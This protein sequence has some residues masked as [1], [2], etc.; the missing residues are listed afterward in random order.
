MPNMHWAVK[1]GNFY[2]IASPFEEP[3]NEEDF[4]LDAVENPIEPCRIFEGSFDE[5]PETQ[6]R[7][8]AGEF[9]YRRRRHGEP[10]ERSPAFEKCP[11]PVGPYESPEFNSPT[12]GKVTI[13]WRL[14][15]RW[16][17]LGFVEPDNP[18]LMLFP[19]LE[20]DSNLPSAIETDFEVARELAGLIV[21]KEDTS[22]LRTEPPKL[23]MAF[24]WCLDQPSYHKNV[25]F[26]VPCKNVEFFSF[27]DVK[28]TM[29][30]HAWMDE[31][32]LSSEIADGD[33]ESGKRR[34]G[35][36]RL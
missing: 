18:S 29:Q 32:E 34:G 2:E 28:T 24:F 16:G 25:G 13:A 3:F 23:S 10:R 19:T 9:I 20:G 36:V 12:E 5:V 35:G 26:Q 14:L 27:V 17:T 1:Q 22:G 30:F 4:V 11:Y 21:L 31:L 7:V 15:G 6:R 8:K 33:E